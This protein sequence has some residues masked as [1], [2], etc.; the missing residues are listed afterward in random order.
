M[1]ILERLLQKRGIT[2]EDLSPE[3]KADFSKWEKVLSKKELSIE[4]F[5]HF[6]QSQVDIIETKWR[7]LNTEQIK[8]AELIPYHTV[9]KTI[10][11]IIKSPEAE[12]SNLEAQLNQIL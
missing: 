11:Q 8:K 1:N 2:H 6:C 10:L 4:D 5:N 7:D 9:Y 3:E 12:R